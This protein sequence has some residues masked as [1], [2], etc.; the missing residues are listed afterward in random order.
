[1]AKNT[2]GHSIWLIPTNPE[3][4]YLQN[5]IS[6]LSERE[7]TPK[8]SPHIT[9]LGQLPQKVEWIKTKLIEFTQKLE[10]FQL[11]FSY[12]GMFDQYFRSIIMHTHLNPFL[13]DLHLRATRH[14]EITNNNTFVPHLSL[15]YSQLEL[16]SKKMLM[17]SMHI[18]FPLTVTITEVVLVETNGGPDQWREVVS[19]PIG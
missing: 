18:G 15:L 13:E 8:F 11:S 4:E 7:G 12:I 1:V 6:Q 19:V 5:L 17:E 3:Y 10:P 14:F 9:L 16:H 2:R